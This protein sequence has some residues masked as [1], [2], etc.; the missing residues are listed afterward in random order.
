MN[1]ILEIDRVDRVAVVEPGVV[2]NDLLNLM[3]GSEGTLGIFTKIV[4][5]LIS[6][7]KKIMDMLVPFPDPETAVRAGP[8]AYFTSDIVM[9]DITTVDHHPEHLWAWADIA[10]SVVRGAE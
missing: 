1:R 2:T 10:M 7:P 5:N 8:N 9:K 4:L 3:I 6:A